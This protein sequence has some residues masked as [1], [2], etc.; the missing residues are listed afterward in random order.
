MFAWHR[1]LTWAVTPSAGGS[2]PAVDT[3]STWPGAGSRSPVGRGVDTRFWR[4]AEGHVGGV[5]GVS[6]LYEGEEIKVMVREPVE[7]LEE[8]LQL[9]VRQPLIVPLVSHEV[10]IRAEGLRP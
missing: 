4:P 2:S 5:L 3:H 6:H 1:P 9:L 10:T 8:Q 7:V